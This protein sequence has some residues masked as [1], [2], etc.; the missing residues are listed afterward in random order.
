MNVGDGTSQMTVK[1]T[2]WPQV[3]QQYF[4]VAQ[5][6]DVNNH[7]RQSGLALEESW[8]TQTWWHRLIATI[9]GIC[10]SDAFLA[11][12]RFSPAPDDLSHREFTAEIAY[13]LIHD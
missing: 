9:V 12:K 5:A 8:K 4:A 13:A 3:V 1:T 7:L 10:E 2:P 11:W 6:S